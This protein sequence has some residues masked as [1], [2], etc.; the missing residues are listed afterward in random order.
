MQTK[1]IAVVGTFTLLFIGSAFDATATPS[2]W[3]AG[4]LFTMVWISAY[5]NGTLGQAA[6]GIIN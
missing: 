5:M 3:V 2:L 1:D 4:I 6:R